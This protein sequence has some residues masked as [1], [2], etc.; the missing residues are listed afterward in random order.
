M[1]DKDY[2]IVTMIEDGVETEYHIQEGEC[3]SCGQTLPLVPR[4]D[5]C[6]ACCWGESDLID[7]EN[8]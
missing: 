6:G 8:W 3:Q 2:R 1:T 4:V 7:P 5:L